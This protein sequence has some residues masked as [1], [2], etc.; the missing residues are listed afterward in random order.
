M[1]HAVRPRQT[2]GKAAGYLRTDSGTC[3][4]TRGV[5]R[6]DARQAADC[7]MEQR[8][9]ARGARCRQRVPPCTRSST[10]RW[11]WAGACVFEGFAQVIATQSAAV[12]GK[13]VVVKVTAQ[14][15][16]TSCQQTVRRGIS[17][18][19]TIRQCICVAVVGAPVVC[20]W[21]IF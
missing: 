20:V 15:V 8:W 18:S 9:A 6:Q 2:R 21:V 7:W 5:A 1:Q 10:H 17:F 13:Q 12:Y 19:K 14:T 16:I 11:W 3:W 4:A